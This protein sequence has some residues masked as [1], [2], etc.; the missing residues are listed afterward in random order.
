MTRVKQTARKG[1]GG[2]PPSQ[3]YGTNM[4]SEVP[5]AVTP[6]TYSSLSSRYY[7]TTTT[8]TTTLFP[9]TYPSSAPLIPGLPVPQP[10]NGG[11]V[12]QT[13]R[14]S[15]G[16]RPPRR[17]APTS[18][19]LES[20]SPH[21]AAYY[22][23]RREPTAARPVVPPLRPQAASHFRLPTENVQVPGS[24]TTRRVKQTA[25]KSTGGRWPA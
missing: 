25:R 1:T 17:T 23:A 3:S 18:A 4:R 14:K 6:G 24:T 5:F 8:T 9:S 7:P 20:P 22:L 10:P 21:S 12:K 16:G 2:R 15:T 19:V 13:A 11:R